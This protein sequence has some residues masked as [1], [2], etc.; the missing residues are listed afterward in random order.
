MPFTKTPMTEEQRREK[1]REAAR[2]YYDANY[3]AVRA[4]QR[5]RDP[6]ARRADQRARRSADPETYRAY[7]RK[8]QAIRREKYPWLAAFHSRRKHAAKKNLP[9]TITTDWCAARYTGKCEL[10]GFLFDVR[11]HDQPG[12][13][14]P[15]P[16][17]VSI[18]KIDATK[19]YTPDNC[20]FVLNAV[21]V[22][23]GS[24]TDDHMRVVAQALITL[25]HP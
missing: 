20:R 13:P 6:V 10:T 16:Y 18:D 2:K 22:M 21:N 23:R 25:P 12:N 17:S 3:D 14:G 15:R 1:K 9:F 19:G 11:K 7:G 8:E 4:Q 24:G 5:T